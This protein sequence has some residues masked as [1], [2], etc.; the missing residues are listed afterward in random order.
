VFEFKPPFLAHVRPGSA[1]ARHLATLDAVFGV[2]RDLLS[3]DGAAEMRRSWGLP[4]A[5]LALFYG[6]AAAAQETRY[7]GDWACDAAPKVNV[8]AFTHSVVAVRAGDRLTISRTVYRAGAKQERRRD[9]PR[10]RHR[11][12]QG[13]ARLDRYIDNNRSHHGPL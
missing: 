13:R 8:P 12:D 1:P 11:D 7:S 2:G 6:A 4:T 9:S 5:S 3:V 10:D